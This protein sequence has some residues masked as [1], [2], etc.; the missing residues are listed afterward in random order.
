MTQDSPENIGSAIAAARRDLAAAEDE[1][2]S[3]HAELSLIERSVGLRMLVRAREGVAEI[4]S[5]V[6][7]PLWSA[8]TIAGK[9]GSLGPLAAGRRAATHLLHRA[10]PLRLLAPVRSWTDRGNATEAVRWIGPLSIRHTPCEAL[11]CHPNSG[12]EFRLNV[13]PGS[14]FVTE[15]GVSPRMWREHPSPVEFAVE[16]RSLSGEWARSAYRTVD[17]AGHVTDRR[18]HRL[19]IAIPAEVQ[20]YG[21]SVAVTLSAVVPSGASTDGAW[22]VFGEPR[23]E[24][25]RPAA[26]VKLSVAAFVSRVRQAGLASALRVAHDAS[27]GQE[28]ERYAKWC[29]ST[30]PTAADLE[31]IA[32]EAK[33]LAFQPRIDIVTPVYNTDPKWLRACIESVRAQ[34]YPHWHLC[35][36]DDASTSA[37]TVAVLREYESDPRISIVR[38]AKNSHISA[39]SNAAL[40]K[41]AGEFVALLDHDDEL[42]PDALFHVARFLNAEPA[43]D[44]IYSDEDKLDL[45]GSRCDPYFKPDWSPDH[46][47]TCMYTCHLMVVRRSLLEEVGAFRRGYEGAQ[48]YDLVLRL[49][50]RTRSIHHIPRILY[51]WRKLPEST[52]SAGLAKPWAMDAGRLALE[53]YIKRNDL[54]ADV[55]PGPAPGVFRIKRTIRGT[56]LVS[57]VIPTA[58][59]L[60]REGAREFDLL[61]SCVRSIRQLTSWQ[62]YELI[63]VAEPAGL[64]PTTLAALD[65]ARHTVVTDDGTA[66]NFSR[67]IN[68]GVSRAKGEHLV[69]LNDDVEVTDPEWLTSMLEQSQ[70]PG[71]GA[72]GAKLLYPDGR[73]QHIGMVL[74]V[75]GLAAHAFHQHPGASPGYASSAVSIR[76]YSA[77][78]AACLMTR[79]TVFDQVGGFDEGLPIDFNDIDFCLRVRQA[80]FRIVFTP[81]AQLFHHESASAGPRDKRRED[82]ELMRQRWGALIDDDPYYNPNLTREGAD[83]RL[84]GSPAVTNSGTWRPSPPDSSGR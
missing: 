81:Y 65:G 46:F 26:E 39:A 69:L 49:M 5:R 52:A 22:A 3:L 27:A 35:L 63:I 75:G 17:A 32:Q 40:E 48:D 59:R 30:S 29:S 1:N 43:A 15:V 24:R 72:V 62:E 70:D 56:P 28:A 60:R 19:R 79:R 73:L 47:L 2:R 44:F 68:L 67:K 21:Q 36:A 34:V 11:L 83:Y 4:A 57:I 6:R 51:H 80:G 55:L 53:D 16:I 20:R 78:T 33:G 74:G 23:L 84:A 8:G 71:V 50:E 37:A 25:R 45:T 82:L 7:H 38:L 42:T 10:H 61:A 66:F 9:V 14:Q 31:L 77:V 54:R 64:Q 18:W 58:G 41:G 76:N 12:V 13:M